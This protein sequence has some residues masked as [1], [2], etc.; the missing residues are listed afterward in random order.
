[1]PN[2]LE[3]DWRSQCVPGA[4]LLERIARE[5]RLLPLVSSET[6]G[7]SRNFKIHGAAGSLGFITPISGH[8]CDSC[9]RIRVS[10]SGMA[11]SCLFAGSS[12]DLKPALR[13]GTP[14]ELRRTLHDIVSSKPMGHELQET[15]N[16][17]PF[18]MSGIG[19]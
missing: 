17:H 4:E 5:H 10:S 1:M 6:A 12:I 13:S 19:G 9:N 3:A 8:F 14:F 11:H 15:D 16:R 2:L 18:A 7:P